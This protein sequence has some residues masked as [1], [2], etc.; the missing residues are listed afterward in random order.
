MNTF[1]TTMLSVATALVFFAPNLASADN[2]HSKS[3]SF[4]STQLTDN[5]YML[6][7]KGGNL[8]L[9]KGK[10]GLLL[11]DADY[12]VMSGALK[13]EL[14]KHGGVE[15]LNYLINT[16]WHGD[17]TQGNFALGHH[18]QIIAHDNVRARLLT[19]Q[20]I[21]LF[22]MVSKPYPE[23]ALPSLTYSTRMSLHI[24]G[25]DIK[26]VHFPNGHTD[27]DS[28]VFFK[29][30][31]IV[32]M[33]DHFFSGFFPFIDIDHGGNV[34][35]MA[36]NIKVILGMVDDKTKIIPG[37]GPLSNKVDLQAFHDMLVGTSAEV[38]AMKDKGMSLEKIQTKGLS[39]KWTPWAEK[40]FFPEKVWIGIVHSS[41]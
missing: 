30:S 17:H 19:T 10:Q 5:I 16:H 27:G 4:K 25:E 39:K 32:H 35:N 6:Q 9:I 18:A 8:G 23:H 24:N 14:A 12:K 15:K 13:T 34:L 37:H 38:K 2:H 11:I 28:V 26:V 41:L 40:S 31:N 33:G 20:E 36:K 1:K 29:N 22:Q 7:G 21:K 3:P